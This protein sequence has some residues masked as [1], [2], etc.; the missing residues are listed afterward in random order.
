MKNKEL[1][2]DQI[3]KILAHKA[4][5]IFIDRVTML[6]ENEE[7]ECIKCISGNELFSGLHFPAY[8][9]YPGI[10]VIEAAAQSAAVLCKLSS[11]FTKS[12]KQNDLMAL[13]GISNF[14][15]FSAAKPGDT[16]I[17]H[18]EI[19]KS[20]A[21]LA[22]VK[23]GIRVGDRLIAKGQMSFGVIKT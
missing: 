16:L 10:F 19:I 22:I 8:S 2:F 23:A 20:V 11:D 21:D 13:G 3:K 9:I 15:F 18:I 1:D 5:F 14:N 17:I 7:I 12:I 4:P 6:K